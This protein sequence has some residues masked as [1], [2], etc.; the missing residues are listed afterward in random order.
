MATTTATIS[1]QE[2][3]DLALSDED[4]FW[5]LW[6]GVPVEKPPMSMKHNAGATYLG[7][8]LINQLD[9]R[10][11]RVTVQGDRARISPRSFYI[12]DVMV[13]PAVYQ[14]PLDPRD[15][16]I[17]AAPLPFVAEVW[18][19]STGRYDITAKLPRYR[20]RGDLEI[21]YVHPYER[22]VTV[23]RRQADGS[24]TE[25]VYTGGIVPILSLPG[26]AIDLDAQL[27]W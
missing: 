12:P 22:T 24:Y 18:S 26:V 7:A 8:A 21:W 1:E 23:W 5:E 10:E 20:Q 17:Y 27:H 16:G 9:W 19:P 25:D 13:I 15:L 14:E 4:R 11:Y 2:F 6:D 3:R